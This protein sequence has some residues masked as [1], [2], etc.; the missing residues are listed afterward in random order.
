MANKRAIKWVL[1]PDNVY[2]IEFENNKLV[3]D[4][5]YDT[6]IVNSLLTDSRANASEV[7]NRNNR[8]GWE[9]DVYAVLEGYKLG[10]KGWLYQNG[11]WN[12]K[13][14]NALVAEYQTALAHFKSK[15]LA[16]RIE[17]KGELDYTN[18]EK[19]NIECIFYIDNND[20]ET[21]RI[22]IWRN[23]EFKQV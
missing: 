5:S 21:F 18:I 15:G 12:R 6:A 7:Q 23:S 3:E 11:R 17:V 13:T 19:I 2:D 14:L 1:Q 9:G 22:E 16:S 10:S 8:R 20:I 4:N